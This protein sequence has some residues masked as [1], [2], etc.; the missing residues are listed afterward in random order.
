[1]VEFNWSLIVV[2]SDIKAPPPP[3]NPHKSV[4][5]TSICGQELK[6]YGE[7]LCDILKYIFAQSLKLQRVPELWK[8]S[9]IVPN[10]KSNLLSC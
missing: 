9:I 2:V 7:Q 1:M 3:K 10:V 4:G 6:N 5:H 8:H